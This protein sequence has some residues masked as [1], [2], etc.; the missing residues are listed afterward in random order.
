MQVVGDGTV[1][2]WR[3]DAMDIV[4][5]WTQGS[6]WQGHIPFGAWLVAVL[7]PKTLV[8]LGA[9]KGTSY[10]AFCQTV[11]AQQL[12]TRC[13]AVDTWSGD[14]HS[15]NYGDGVFKRLNDFNADNFSGFSTLLRMTFDD[16]LSQFADKSI[17]L[18]H[19]DGFHSYEAVKHDY[20]TWLPKMSSNGVVL[21]HDTQI[22]QKDFGVWKFW[23]EVRRGRESFEFT[24][25]CGLGVMLLGGDL[26]PKL[27]TL[28]A[29]MNRKHGQ[30]PQA[31]FEGL[32]K[33]ID[34]VLP[35]PIKK[36]DPWSK[37]MRSIK[38]RL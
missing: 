20:E 5:L 33:K 28:C 17:D 37:L 29:E 15:G 11:V 24:H 23:Q 3:H 22:R 32:A 34:R 1:T 6:I 36:N 38:K 4:P 16:A 7:A 19:I 21:F 14:P 9:Y 18:L 35:N 26:P 12:P 27:L 25:S 2:D 13:F 31:S 8:E 30:G 10:A